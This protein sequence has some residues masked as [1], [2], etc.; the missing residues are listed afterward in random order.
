MQFLKNQLKLL[1]S[2]TIRSQVIWILAVA[3]SMYYLTFMVLAPI[4]QVECDWVCIQ[5][6]WDRW[7]TLNAAMIALLA[8]AGAIYITQYNERRN[9]ERRFLASRVLLPQALSELTTYLEKSA[10]FYI[11]SKACVEANAKAEEEGEDK[12]PLAAILPLHTDDYKAIF[13]RCIESAEV[14]PAIMLGDVLSDLQ[15]LEARMRRMHEDLSASERG[16]MFYSVRNVLAD[17]FL[18]SHVKVL[19][20]RLFDFARG[21]GTL[22][23]QAFQLDEY[24][25]ALNLLPVGFQ[26]G[27]MDDVLE[28]AARHLEKRAVHPDTFSAHLP[29]VSNADTP[30]PG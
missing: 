10:T 25:S 29:P 20:D 1:S 17:I 7:Q 4:S 24:K 8:S 30:R 14:Q 27:L 5:E 6:I 28:I 16:P 13:S 18:I 15:V 22:N 21:R 2:T 9:T 23:C 3:I 11:A 26:F 19:V 12:K